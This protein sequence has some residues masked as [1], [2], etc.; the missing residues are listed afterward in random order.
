MKARSLLDI[1]EAKWDPRKTQ[2]EDYEEPDAH[3]NGTDSVVFD[4]RVTTHGMVADVFRIFTQGDMPNLHEAAPN[5]KHTADP[6]AATVIAYTDGSA[7]NN[8]GANARARAGNPGIASM[9]FAIDGQASGSYTPDDKSHPRDHPNQG[10]E[11]RQIYIDYVMYPT[12]SNAVQWYYFDDRDPAHTSSESSSVGDFFSFQF[13]G[14]GISFYGGLTASDMGMQASIVPIVLDGGAPVIYNAP[15][16]PPSITNN[17]IYQSPLLSDG[18]H[19]IVVTGETVQSVWADYFLVTPSTRDLHRGEIPRDDGTGTG[20]AGASVP[21]GSHASVASS[22]RSIASGNAAGSGFSGLCFPSG[23]SGSGSSNSTSTTNSSNSTSSDSNSSTLLPALST[24][25]SK[26]TA[27]IAAATGCCSLR[28]CVF[29]DG[30]GNGRP[31]K[32][33]SRCQAPRHA[34]SPTSYQLPP[35]QDSR[36][37]PRSRAKLVLCVALFR[38]LRPPTTEETTAPASSPSPPPQMQSSKLAV[39][40]LWFQTNPNPTQTRTHRASPSS[41][42]GA[43]NVVSPGAPSFIGSSLTGTSDAPPQ[44]CAR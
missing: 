3:E 23:L 7:T 36:H 11:R 14:K 38:L 1:L 22:A 35:P 43:A 31:G 34:P 8:G 18:T 33:D 41:V 13:Q 10:G 12:T 16:S 25:K 6:T 30:G 9:S 2:P 26:P 27:A 4:P 20:T 17:L 32:L 40:A 15:P 21:S 42:S 19:T 37:Y 44:Y 39:E 5:T 29:G 28:F 24:T